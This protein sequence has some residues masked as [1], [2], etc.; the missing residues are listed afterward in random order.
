MCTTGSKGEVPGKRKP[1]IRDDDG[2]NNKNN[3]CI[4]T[5]FGIALS[6]NIPSMYHKKFP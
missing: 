6:A 2:D 4:M 5:A 1:V 3:K